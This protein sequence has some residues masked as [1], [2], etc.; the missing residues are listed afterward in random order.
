MM[1][2]T[3]TVHSVMYFA[4]SDGR[5]LRFNDPGL[6]VQSDG[7]AFKVKWNHGNIDVE[8]I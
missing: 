3:T 6:A 5:I 8:V 2:N 7:H 4:V 1:N